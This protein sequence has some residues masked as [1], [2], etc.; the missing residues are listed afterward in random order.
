MSSG[1]PFRPLLIAGLILALAVSAGP[2]RAEEAEVL[3]IGASRERS[4]ST[5][6][7]HAFR[8]EVGEEPLLVTVEQQD[9]DLVVEVQGPGQ[10]ETGSLADTGRWGPVVVLLEGAGERRIAVRPRGT[11]GWPGRYTLRVETLAEAPVAQRR[12]LALMSRAGAEAVAATPEARRQA[13]ATYREA[14]A[15]WHTLGE[16]RREAEALACLAVLEQDSRELRQAAEDYG[17]ALA[18]WRQLDE[19]L[20]QAATLNG[21]GVA[22][23]SR[24]E[25]EGAREALQD[26]L[27]LW[28]RLGQRFDAAET[29][30]NLC[31]LEQSVGALPAALA[32]YAAPRAVFQSIG[33]Q[34]DEAQILNSLG[35]IYDLQGEPDTALE[36]YTQA[37]KLRRA[38]GDHLGEAQTLNN[39]AVVHRGLGEWQEALRL[40]GEEREILE[41]L[42]DR[43]LLAPLLSNVGYTYNSLGEPQRALPFLQDALKLRRE[44]GDRRGEV[45]TLNNLGLT[46][47]ELGDAR[48]A[49]D[50][51]QQA[52]ALAAGLSDARQEALSRLRLGEARLELGDANAALREIDPSL[53][54]LRQ[55]GLRQGEQEA[56]QLRGRALTV[57]GRPRE[58]IPVFQEILAR[59]RTLR[60][61]AGEAEAL[62]GLA[63][64]ERSAGL[65]DEARVHAEAAVA[66]VEELRTGFVSPSLRAAFLATQRRAYALLVDLYMDR[67]A[68]DP[69]GGWDRAAFAVNEQARARSLL[70]ALSAVG[71][72]GRAGSAV[73]AELRARRQTLRRRL[74]AKADQRV[75][76]N[77]ARAE[78]LGQEI[79]A[80]LADLD[81]VDAEIRRYDP[82]A[83]ALA[84][85]QPVGPDEIS[86]LLDPGTLLLEYALGE[87]RSFLWV[88]GAGRLRTFVL[89]AEREIEALARQVYAEL[90]T[91][92]AGATHR[93]EAAAA[94]GQI[95][96]GPAWGEIAAAGRLVIVPDAAL[97]LLP[98]GAL[99]VP[100]KGEPLLE[101]AEVS[102]L[103]SATTLALQ[104]QRL[105]G[106]PPAPKWAAVLADPV[107][108]AGDARLALAPPPRDP[109][110]GGEAD[111]LLP[112]FERLR[113]SRQEAQA[114]L[115]LA[116]PGQVWTALDLA[117]S[118]EA[119]LSGAL[120]GYR[121]VH[122]AT[123]AVADTRNPELSGLVLSRV[124]AAG[125]PREGFLAL[126]DIYD[127]DL[128][129]GL[130][131]LSGCRTAVGKEVR[132]EGLMGLTRGFLYAGVP[133][134]VASLWPVQDRTTT[135]LMTRFYSAMWRGGSS[136]A[137]ALRQAQRD[138]RHDPR[139]R[140][141][142][143]WA[144][145]VLQGDWR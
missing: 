2:G 68:A 113:F 115:G 102:Y 7:K 110:R 85:P 15:A 104:R 131:V 127:L 61:R 98:F 132:G 137:A 16:R 74:S 3:A 106:R 138:L 13:A 95:L 82:Q 49:L 29:Q 86:R 63:T 105:A 71:G 66:R 55:N 21:L 10:Q 12:A 120:R 48:K 17:R 80:L 27:S 78:A 60:D 92:E 18:L 116:P 117:A 81:S 52:L 123:H 54:Y 1:N 130:V 51:H 121:I 91:V 140:E 107:F 129:A 39:I 37:L 59:C 4:I 70:D 94:L 139:Y 36:E 41:R 109:D 6:E 69:S 112:A 143:S 90:S 45:I 38:L 5:G 89:P 103:P 31:V 122:F 75:G 19:P 101:H 88:A 96:L 67:H 93:G 100:G 114:I 97:H 56:L 23:L 145:F 77:G 57:A 35:G 42:G 76:L 58:A 53:A 20:R 136:P 34:R 134:V 84:R 142:F 126:S 32:C 46:W 28:Q 72:G 83:A 14:A 30:S 47:R 119:V 87:E 50:H 128:D 73:P 99:P 65:A 44:T 24:G 43:T 22:R 124:D 144:G 118:R 64:A 135:E 133:R 8:V 141:P 33:D 111:G 108:S 26:A 125:H 11:P 40:Y 79:E 25:T 9:V 62:H